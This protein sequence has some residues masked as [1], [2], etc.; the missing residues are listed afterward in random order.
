MSEEPTDDPVRGPAEPG[1]YGR[2]V[3]G[4]TLENV[5]I[6]FCSRVAGYF[7]GDEHV[8]RQSLIS[9]TSTEGFFVIGSSDVL[10]EKNI[11]RRKTSRS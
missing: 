8:L 3:V 5:T 11:F 6:S 2:E 9:D 7:R 1:T 4:T 10:L